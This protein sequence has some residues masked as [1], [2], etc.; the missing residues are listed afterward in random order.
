MLERIPTSP[1]IAASLC[2]SKYAIA[3]STS[4]TSMSLTFAVILDKEEMSELREDNA[5]LDSLSCKSCAAF[6][7]VDLRDSSRKVSFNLLT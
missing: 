2:L 4:V 6:F 3:S 5:L 7:T 1:F